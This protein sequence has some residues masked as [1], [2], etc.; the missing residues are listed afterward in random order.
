M[1]CCLDHLEE[2]ED[3]DDCEEVGAGHDKARV[4]VA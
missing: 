1:E 4:G 3:I 2:A